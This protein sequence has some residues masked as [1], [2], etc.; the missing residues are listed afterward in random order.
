VL[1]LQCHLGTETLAF[2][3]RGART[4]GLDFSGESVRAAR[5]LA[6]ERGLDVTYVEA[7]VYAAAERFAREFDVVYTGKGALCYLPD[8]DRWASVVAE[9]LRPGGSCY[10]VEFHPLLYSLGVV[11]PPDGGEELLLRNDFLRGAGPE[12][13]DATFTY[14]DGPALT[15]ATVA[16]EWRHEVGEVV[17]ALVGAGLRIERLREDPRLPWP[18]WPSMVP[19]ADGWFS[20]PPP[21]PR[22][23]LLYAVLATKA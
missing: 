17:T 16:Y 15:E 10:V 6:E 20:L 9:L 3:E 13:R 21:A 22:I 11:P 7:D 4:F 2:A 5:R 19:D 12:K 1:H 23:P 18:R 8:L 14:T